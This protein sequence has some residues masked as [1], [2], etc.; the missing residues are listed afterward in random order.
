MSFSYTPKDGGESI[1]FPD[2]N[3]LWEEVDG[4]KPVVFL[5]R[6]RKM[7]EPYQ[8]FAFMERAKVDDDMAERA[9]DLDADERQEMFRQWFKG[10]TTPEPESDLP[11][12][13]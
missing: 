10:V 5:W 7:Q 2:A 12:E 3:V 8:T 6:L 11:P 9:L 4:V 13:S 1:V